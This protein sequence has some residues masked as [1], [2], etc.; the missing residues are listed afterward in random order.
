M[1]THIFPFFGALMFLVFIL[2]G[3]GIF[4]FVGYWLSDVVYDAG[5]WP[6]G[7]V[8]RIGLLLRLLGYGFMVLMMVFLAIRNLV[9]CDPEALELERIERD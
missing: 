8:M 4:L 5:L 7:A 6:I 9:L 2:V 3:G 1:R